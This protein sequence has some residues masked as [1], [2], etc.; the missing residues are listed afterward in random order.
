ME[1]VEV[2]R[3]GILDLQVC[4]EKSIS[5]DKVEEITN[6]I[7]PAGTTHG[8]RMKKEGHKGLSGDPYRRQCADHEDR[9]H[10]MFEC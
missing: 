10:I 2:V 9:V 6:F 7:S 3:S 1:E 5:D 4:A 8:W